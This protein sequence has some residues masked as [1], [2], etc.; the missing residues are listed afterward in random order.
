MYI[1]IYIYICIYI[2]IYVYICIYIYVY[3]YVYIY[4]YIYILWITSNMTLI[5]SYI[6]YIYASYIYTLLLIYHWQYDHSVM[7]YVM[8]IYIYN[9]YGNTHRIT[10]ITIH[11]PLIAF[12]H[13]DPSSADTT[14][15]PLL[16]RNGSWVA[17]NE[18]SETARP[19]PHGAFVRRHPEKLLDDF[20]HGKSIYKWFSSWKILFFHMDD[21]GH[22]SI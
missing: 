21:L 18:R 12:S 9:I 22:L 4:M 1:Y 2:C 11:Q 13:L 16:R 20:F 15:R 7:S 5:P 6:I 17:K 3:I 14:A 10:I 8:N 19:S